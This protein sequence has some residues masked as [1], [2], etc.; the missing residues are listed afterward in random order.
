MEHQPFYNH[1]PTKSEE[2]QGKGN[3]EVS[4]TVE[5]RPIM[6]I[7]KY[8]EQRDLAER[9]IYLDDSAVAKYILPYINNGQHIYNVNVTVRD[10]KTRKDYD[11]LFKRIES[12]VYV[13]E[14]C[15]LLFKNVPLERGD[16][17][18]L[19][20]SGSHPFTLLLEY[21]Y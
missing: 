8:L 19:E 10:V 13:I 18:R 7:R 6:P 17:I 3:G 5:I 15:Q 4:G 20:Y 14:G 2:S 9:R 12:G 16:L 11:M 21:G 1:F